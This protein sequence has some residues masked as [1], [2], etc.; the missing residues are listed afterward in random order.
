MDNDKQ[1]SHSKK[2]NLENVK[3]KI[4]VRK[5]INYREDEIPDC[6]CIYG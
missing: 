4:E 2:E 6:G 5:M 3:P 1:K